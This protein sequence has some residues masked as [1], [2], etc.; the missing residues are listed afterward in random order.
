MPVYSATKAWPHAFTMALRHQVLKLGI[1]VFEVVPPAVDTEL[2]PEGRAQRGHFKAGVTPEQF[3]A[4][5]MEG[6]ERDAFEIG[7]GMSAGMLQ[8]SRANL[9]RIFTQMNNRW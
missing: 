2:N 1:K 6:L 3:T 8:A 9:D 5:V 7:Y 4:A